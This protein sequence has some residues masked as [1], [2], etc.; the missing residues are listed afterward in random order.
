MVRLLP[1]GVAILG[2]SLIPFVSSFDGDSLQYNDY[3]PSSLGMCNHA[4]PETTDLSLLSADHI[5]L[6]DAAREQLTSV[7]SALGF[8]WRAAAI[9]ALGPWLSDAINSCKQTVNEEA[10]V[11]PCLTGALKTVVP[12][13]A[14]YQQARIL[15]SL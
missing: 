13:T 6:V 2:L 4:V 10:G 14:L 3:V 7:S 8:T 9:A 1:A 12:F 15:A 11:G 5:T